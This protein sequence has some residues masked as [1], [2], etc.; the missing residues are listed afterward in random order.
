[1]FTEFSQILLALPIDECQNKC[2][3]TDRTK[4]RGKRIGF[5]FSSQS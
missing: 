4:E 2:Y 3:I 1:M 5:H